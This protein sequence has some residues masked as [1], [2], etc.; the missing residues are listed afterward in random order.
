[1]VLAGGI[2]DHEDVAWAKALGVDG[3]QAATRF[4]A[5]EECDASMEYKMAYVNAKSE[6][7]KII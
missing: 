7:V 3:V 5:T 4:V 6:D 1:M 2:W